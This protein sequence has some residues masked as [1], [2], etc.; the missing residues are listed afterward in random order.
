LFASHHHSAVV[1]PNVSKAFP[2]E[3][4]NGQSEKIFNFS[5][6]PRKRKKNFS[7]VET[8]SYKRFRL[9]NRHGTGF[10]APG[11]LI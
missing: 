10:I 7:G 11:L 9:F 5:E 2:I 8:G 6:D 3:F 4:L 1:Q